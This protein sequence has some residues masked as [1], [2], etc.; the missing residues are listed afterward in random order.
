MRFLKALPVLTVLLSLVLGFGIPGAAADDLATEEEESIPEEVGEDRLPDS[1]FDDALFIGDSLTGSLGTYNLLNGGLGDAIVFHMNGLACHHLIQQNKQI[2][3]MGE[4]CSVERAAAKAGVN[5]LFLM[6]AMND[7]GAP[8]EDLQYCWETLLERL[9]ETCPELTVY[10]QSGTPLRTD[11]FYFT[12]D[13]MDAYNEM[14]QAVCEAYDCVYVDITEGLEDEEGYMKKEYQLD[15]VHLNPEGCAIW[16][17]NLHR[18][19][20]YSQPVTVD[21]A[22]EP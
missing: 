15:N 19:S 12:R 8:L 20:C 3:F 9:R 1:F 16:M 2:Y 13:N 14:L 10:I 22:L 4:S 18:A 6:L 17:E 11:D 21:S 5:K 7:I